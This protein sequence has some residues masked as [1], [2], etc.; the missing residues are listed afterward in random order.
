MARA[1]DLL[2]PA[3]ARLASAGVRD[4]SRDAR[5]LLGHATGVGMDRLTLVLPEEMDPEMADVFE[6]LITRRANREPVSHLI[7]LRAFYGR[8]FIVSNEVLDP[9]P[10]TETLIEVALAQPFEDCLDLGTGSG[11]ILLSLL[12]DR[13]GARGVGVDI[14]PAATKTAK[15]NAARFGLRGRAEFHTASWYDGVPPKSDKGSKRGAGTDQVFDLQTFD[16][17]VSNPP[18]IALNEIEAL[19]PEVRLFE[20]RQ[21]LTDGG[22]GL[23]AY[24]AIVE[25]VHDFLRPNGRLIVEIGPTQAYDVVDLFR[26]AGLRQVAVVQDLDARDRVVVGRADSRPRDVF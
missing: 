16:L 1:V 9:R 26:M 19:E 5:R 2:I 14:S 12:A 23:D 22:D 24:R 17:I 13:P 8:E 15:R 18:Y 11:C 25:G 3:I 7:G 21:A 10:E 20:P 6:E 4:A